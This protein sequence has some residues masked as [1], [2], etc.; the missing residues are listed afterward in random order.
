MSVRAPEQ[1]GKFGNRVSAIFVPIPTD[2]PGPIARLEKTHR[3]LRS[4]K[5]RHQAMPAERLQDITQS[6]R[7]R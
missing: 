3:T 2:E 6:S 1:M 4:A 7:R 5:A